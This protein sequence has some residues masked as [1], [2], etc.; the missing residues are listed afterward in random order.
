MTIIQYQLLT[1]DTAI[2]LQIQVQN[3]IDQGWQPFGSLCY[4]SNSGQPWRPSI[5]PNNNPQFIQAMVK[6]SA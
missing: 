2:D 1:K 5:N 6:Y 4:L 3:Y